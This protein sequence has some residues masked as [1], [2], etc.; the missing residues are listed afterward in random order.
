MLFD[1][2]TKNFEKDEPIFLSE[3]PGQSRELV[4]Q[5][6][7]NLANEGKVKRLCDGTYHRSYATIL[8][9]DGKA[10]V[11]K[12]IQKKYLN[13]N[14]KTTGYITGLPLA[15]M[16]GFTTQ[17]PSCYE[18]CSNEAMTKQDEFTIDGRKVILYKPVVAITEENKGTLQFLD[19]MSTID[20]YSDISGDEFATKMKSFII[21]AGVDLNQV[22]KYIS[23]FPDR[24]YRNICEKGLMDGL[25]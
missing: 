3:L 16:Y 22:Q 18:I 10:S 1:Y 2:I 25:T 20:V 13:V 7:E 4:K 24:T 17:I 19:L 15:N 12:F 8:G 9:T 14:G 11:N 23:L 5:E 6:M 21:G